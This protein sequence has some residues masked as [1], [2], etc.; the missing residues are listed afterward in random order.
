MKTQ[1]PEVT[2]SHFQEVINSCGSGVLAPARGRGGE[3]RGR[4]AG[5][6]SAPLAWRQKKS[7]FHQ[8]CNLLRRPGKAKGILAAPS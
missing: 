3:G 4:P 2:M 5:P 8:P 6:G 7:I 1:A